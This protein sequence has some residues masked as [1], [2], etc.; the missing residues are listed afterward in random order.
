[1]AHHSSELFNP[2]FPEEFQ[3]MVTDKLDK[4]LG[5]HLTKLSQHES[6]GATG[7]FPQGKL[8]EDDEGEIR[9]GVSNFK[10]KVVMNFGK[11]IAWIGF[12]AEQ[13]RKIAEILLKH[14]DKIDPK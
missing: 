1:M 10:G 7:E 14:A 3:K 8:N 4:R 6:F 2:E 13:A 9:L 11:S 5:N 12:D